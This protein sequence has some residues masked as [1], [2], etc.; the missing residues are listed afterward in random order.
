MTYQRPGAVGNADSIR[1]MEPTRKYS[2]GYFRYY[3][4]HGQPLDVHGKPGP[5]S[6]THIP[7]EYIGRIPEWPRR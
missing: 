2:G 4:E 5:P 7:E 1:V 3:N 6:A